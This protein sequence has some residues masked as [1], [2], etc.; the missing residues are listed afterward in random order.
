MIDLTKAR[1]LLKAAMETQ[2]RDF[3]YSPA[4]QGCFYQPITELP[5]DY[6][7]D[8]GSRNITEDDPRRKTGCL[9]GVALDLHGETRHHGF[10]GRVRDL[11]NRYP[12]MM[13]DEAC[14]YFSRAQEHQDSGWTWGSAYDKA[15]GSIQYM[16]E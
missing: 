2:G 15:E 13:T 7:R 3:V 16:S 10:N 4:G 12:D 8:N 6:P 14:W 11:F 9:I 1:E 5:S